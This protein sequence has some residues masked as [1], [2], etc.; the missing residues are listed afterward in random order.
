[1]IPSVLPRSSVPAG[2]PQPSGGAAVLAMPSGSPRAAASISIAGRSESRA[3]CP[4]AFLAVFQRFD[5]VRF[6][7]DRVGPVAADLL[8]AIGAKV[9][10]IPK[11][12]DEENSNLD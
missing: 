12:I 4:L 6:V 3:R 7:L 2:P 10:Y 11:V 9:Y 5:D 8:E 1:M